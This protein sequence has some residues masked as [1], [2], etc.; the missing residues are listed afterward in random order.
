MENRE[1]IIKEI[2]SYRSLFKRYGWDYSEVGIDCYFLNEIPENTSNEF[3]SILR[4]NG[5]V[6][7]VTIVQTHSKEL[8]KLKMLFAKLVNDLS[9]ILLH[10]SNRID[11]DDSLHELIKFYEK[12]NTN[13]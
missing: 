9:D 10:E 12:N 2:L 8:L 13:Y 11:I 7:V 6:S 5:C 3:L 4:N 1:Q